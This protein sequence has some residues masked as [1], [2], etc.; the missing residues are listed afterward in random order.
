[1]L[2]SFLLSA[3]ILSSTAASAPASVDAMQRS[4][5]LCFY[6]T[7]S[8]FLETISHRDPQSPI[9]GPTDEH[10]WTGIGCADGLIRSIKYDHVQIPDFR[11]AY[12][13]GTAVDVILPGN[14]IQAEID[15]AQLPREL[16]HCNIRANKIFGT[17]NM[18][19]LPRNLRTLSARYNQIS[20]IVCLRHLPP[21]IAYIELSN[22]KISATRVYYGEIPSS[23][24]SIELMDNN[25][26]R[27][28]PFP[29]VFLN[30][31]EFV[32][33]KNAIVAVQELYDSMGHMVD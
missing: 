25:V 26:K 23:T 4:L 11:V 21:Q 13:P 28:K 31:N 15:T 22:N 16:Q 20:G 2:A 30:E 33:Y 6:G 14:S 24:K 8:A 9:C 27:L 1:M 5:M 32:V 3:P 17:F 7:N 18:T 19:T 29:G 10:N 12:L